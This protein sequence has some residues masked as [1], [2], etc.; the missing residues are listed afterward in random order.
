[1]PESL[2][3]I[4]NDYTNHFKS[5]DLYICEPA[6]FLDAKVALFD[7]ILGN[8]LVRNEDSD[9]WH[10][11]TRHN[12][13]KLNGLRTIQYQHCPIWYYLKDETIIRIRTLLDNF[14]IVNPK[15]M[16][17]IIPIT[18]N[19]TCVAFALRLNEL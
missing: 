8:K 9:Y 1:M 4:Q 12:Q 2:V 19:K 6:P 10:Y 15:L 7:P 16:D 3:L 18:P 5:I 14:N 17:L 13:L 11:T